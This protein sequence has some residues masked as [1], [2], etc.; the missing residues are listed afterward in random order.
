MRIEAIRPDTEGARQLIERSDEYMGQL[1]PAESNHLEPLEALGCPNVLFVGAYIDEV[2][3]GCGAVKLANDDGRY[4]EIKRMYIDERYRGLGISKAIMSHLES[5]LIESDVPLARI[6][7]GIYQPEAIGLYKRLGY[8][9][10]LPF[11]GYKFDPLSV[12]MQK[13]LNA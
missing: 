11:G 13:A 10:R 2:L 8:V 5:Y 1:Y 3:V 6:E 12:F 9:E 7:T 4:G